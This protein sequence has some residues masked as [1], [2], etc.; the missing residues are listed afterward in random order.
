MI[1]QAQAHAKQVEMAADALKHDSIANL[2]QRLKDKTKEV[3][4][5]KAKINEGENKN[6]LTTEELKSKVQ[7]AL[8]EMAIKE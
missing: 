5:L 4:D 1:E 6:H 3:E 8:K 2:Q 7:Q